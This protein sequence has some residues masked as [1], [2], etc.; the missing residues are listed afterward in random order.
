MKRPRFRPAR[1]SIA[2]PPEP[3]FSS[4]AGQALLLSLIAVE[5]ES[6]AASSVD[7]IRHRFEDAIESAY[8]HWPEDVARWHER[9]EAW[10]PI[11]CE[12]EL[13][14]TSG[15]IVA[16]VVLL[17]GGPK[18]MKFF[19]C[20]RGLVQI[21]TSADQRLP[22]F[23]KEPQSIAAAHEQARSI[24]KLAIKVLERATD[25]FPQSAE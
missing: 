11:V 4:V 1:P 5:S 21:E 16:P 3:A 10:T 20:R 12:I 19:L 9:Q 8:Q 25:P 14:P 7:R 23:L 6:Q 15:L 17:S 22:A 24:V 13:S 2:Q 18:Q